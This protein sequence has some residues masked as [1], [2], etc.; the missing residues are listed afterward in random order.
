[1]PLRNGEYFT[2]LHNGREHVFCSALRYFEITQWTRCRSFVHDMRCIYHLPILYGGLPDMVKCVAF[3][4][5]RGRRVKERT[6]EVITCTPDVPVPPPRERCVDESRRCEPHDRFSEI[7][8]SLAQRKTH[9]RSRDCPRIRRRSILVARVVC[10]NCGNSA[11]PETRRRPAVHRYVCALI[12][13]IRRMT[14]M[15]ALD[16]TRPAFAITFPTI[17]FQIKRPCFKQNKR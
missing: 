6:F 3:G 17:I 4:S 12:I 9:A 10:E 13:D 15:L 8:L 7:R 5:L 11:G 14:S 2:K 1:M 16:T